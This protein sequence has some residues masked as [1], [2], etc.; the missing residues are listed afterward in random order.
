MYSCRQTATVLFPDRVLVYQGK[1]VGAVSYENLQVYQR[2]QRFIESGSVPKDATIVDYTW[3]YQ[4]KS[5]GPDK[6]FSNNRRLPM[7]LYSEVDFTSSTGLN[8]RIQFSRPDVGKRLIQQLAE[9]IKDVNCK[10]DENK[11]DSE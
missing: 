2:N 4:N 8:E 7:A 5:G 3:Q 9:L 1:N 10:V 11:Q 6:R